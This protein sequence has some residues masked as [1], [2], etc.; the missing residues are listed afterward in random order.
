MLSR[1]KRVIACDIDDKKLDAAKSRGAAETCNLQDG[2]SKRIG[3]IA[4]GGLHGMLD[5]VGAPSTL[6]LAAPYLRKGGKIV[7]CGLF[8]GMASIPIAVLPLRE[9]AILGSLVGSTQELIEL[10]A[11]AKRGQIQLGDVERRPMNA[12][13][14]SL[15]DLAGGRVIGRVVL[16]AEP[17]SDQ[18]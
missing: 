11:L 18:L 1:Y 2:G 7:V 17:D 8:G 14:R 3:E 10:V 4:G 13:E 5:F 6:A 9:I 15:S 16:E 12:A